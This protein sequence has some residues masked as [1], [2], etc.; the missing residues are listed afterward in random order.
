M[1]TSRIHYRNVIFAFLVTGMLYMAMATQAKYSPQSVGYRL[2]DINLNAS[3]APNSIGTIEA[4]PAATLLLPYFEVD[5]GS[6]NGVNT[7][8]T[9]R[10]ASPDAVVAHVTA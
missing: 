5:L 3:A 9:V 10:N 2:V 1:P 8:F 4:V 7:L 6:F